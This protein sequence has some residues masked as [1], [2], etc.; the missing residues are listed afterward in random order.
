M[1]SLQAS[2]GD[3]EDELPVKTDIDVNIP[4]TK[5]EYDTPFPPIKVAIAI[6]TLILI[7]A[8]T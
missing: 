5:N 4:L 7:S 8:L 6:S 3:E 1:W 2:E